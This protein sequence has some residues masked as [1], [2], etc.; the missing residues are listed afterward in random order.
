MQDGG[1]SKLADTGWNNVLSTLTVFK[2][3]LHCF[4][5]EPEKMGHAFILSVPYVI[6]T[7]KH[8]FL[9]KRKKK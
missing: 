7:F 4:A 5:S 9:K 6:D 2:V 3:W 1:R 8:L